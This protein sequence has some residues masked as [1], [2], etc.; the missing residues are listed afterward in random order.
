MFFRRFF[1]IDKIY[2]TADPPLFGCASEAAGR[3]TQTFKMP[4][5][6]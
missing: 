5:L 6:L 2:L 1:I 3:P 4:E